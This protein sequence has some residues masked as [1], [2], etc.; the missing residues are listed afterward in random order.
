MKEKERDQCFVIMPKKEIDCCPAPS[1]EAA[2]N[3][4]LAGLTSR[5]REVASLLAVGWSSKRISLALS[6]TVTIVLA[7]KKNIQRKLQARSHAEM[8]AMIK[9]AEA[10]RPDG[11]FAVGETQMARRNAAWRPEERPT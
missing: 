10:C 2:A 11:P 4:R 3:Q 8:L 7:H 9:D 6:V 1:M 5:E